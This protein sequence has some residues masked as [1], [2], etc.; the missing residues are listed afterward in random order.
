MLLSQ[1]LIITNLVFLD[2]PRGIGMLWIHIYP[3]KNWMRY[4]THPLLDFWETIRQIMSFV[5]YCL[6][7]WWKAFS[8]WGHV[9]NGLTSYLFFFK[10]FFFITSEKEHETVVFW[11][12]I[13]EKKNPNLA[14]KN[15]VAWHKQVRKEN[16]AYV[17]H[18]WVLE[19]KLMHREEYVPVIPQSLVYTSVQNSWLKIHKF[20]ARVLIKGR[21]SFTCFE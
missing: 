5:C 18:L 10:I 11:L 12:D 15:L 20:V 14:G 17:C 3:M 6:S 2:S 9:G 16:P 1:L 19:D 21:W 13:L 7:W 4:S 8:V